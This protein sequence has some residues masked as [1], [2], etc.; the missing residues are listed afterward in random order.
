MDDIY[1]EIREAKIDFRVFRFEDKKLYIGD[2]YLFSVEMDL[3]EAFIMMRSGIK[4]FY[5]CPVVLLFLISEKIRTRYLTQNMY[6]R[7]WRPDSL[8]S[9]IIN[10][11]V[12]HYDIGIMIKPIDWIKYS[13][14]KKFYKLKDYFYVTGMVYD[15]KIIENKIYARNV[16]MEKHLKK[17]NN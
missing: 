1:E 5:D 10:M 6:N 17:L 3:M 9:I 16:Q 4:L 8:A 15:K 7:I 12:I 13:Q 2:S 14:V 11:I